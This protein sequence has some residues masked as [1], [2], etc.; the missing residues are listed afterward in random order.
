M[1]PDPRLVTDHSE[2]ERLAVPPDGL[3]FAREEGRLATSEFVALCE[4]SG[5]VRPIQDAGRITAMIEHSNLLVTARDDAGRLVGLARSLTDFAYCC[6]LSD[7]CVDRAWQGRHVGRALIAETKR[8]I[9]PR[10]MLLLLSAAEPMSYYPHIGMDMVR[11]GFII[12]R[13]S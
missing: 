13:S 8:I 9:G 12:R 5:L 7:L 3:V 6:Y 2:W 1:T 11:N 10:S 4:S